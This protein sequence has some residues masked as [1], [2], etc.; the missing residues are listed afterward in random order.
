MHAEDIRVESEV[1]KDGDG[2]ARVRE[3]NR[4]L[5]LLRDRILDASWVD[6]VGP[7]P[8]YAILEEE[9]GQLVDK[10]VDWQ[11][12]G[13]LGETSWEKVWVCQAMEALEALRSC[14]E[15][16]NES[17]STSRWSFEKVLAAYPK[18]KQKIEEVAAGVRASLEA[19][20][21]KGR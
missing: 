11:P 15:K 7:S 10:L 16:T 6:L 4:Q 14:E 13:T 19:P 12:K 18:L 1:Q 5:D 2:D 9:F 3:A 20:R 17:A 21:G 8:D